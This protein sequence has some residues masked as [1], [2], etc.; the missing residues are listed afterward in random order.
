MGQA[1]QKAIDCIEDAFRPERNEFSARI[2]QA[3]RVRELVLSHRYTF[4]QAL[5][6]LDARVD[7]MLEAFDWMA[8]DNFSLTEKY[9]RQFDMLDVEL[10]AWR[11][12]RQL[13]GQA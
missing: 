5:E 12:L 9:G 3:C 6:K 8:L 7:W 11:W 2:T 1:L 10:A 4:Q 13:T